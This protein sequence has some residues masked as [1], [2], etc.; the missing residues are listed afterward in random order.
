ML[1]AVADRLGDDLRRKVSYVHRAL[2]R[3]EIAPDPDPVALGAV[4][5]GQQLGAV[6][7]VPVGDEEL[8]V[9][10]VAEQRSSA[11]GNHDVIDVK[12]LLVGLVREESDW[13]LGKGRIHRRV[14]QLSVEVRAYR[15][16]LQFGADVMQLPLTDG[17]WQSH[18]CNGRPRTVL[19]DVLAKR[20]G[21]RPAFGGNDLPHVCI[22]LVGRAERPAARPADRHDLEVE[23]QRIVCP[24]RARDGEPEGPARD[25]LVPF[26]GNRE[27][28][29]LDLPR[30]VDVVAARRADL[31]RINAAVPDPV[32]QVVIAEEV[33]V[34]GVGG[35]KVGRVVDADRVDRDGPVARQ[36]EQQITEA[37]AVVCPPGDPRPAGDGQIAQVKSRGIAADL[38][39]LKPLAE[40]GP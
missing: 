34:V 37:P 16:A 17:L 23:V 7:V 14:N 33:S 29:L 35:A 2:R 12:V 27:H 31:L 24:L 3:V 6:P 21:V 22:V 15:G 1:C 13:A 26:E 32:H 25:V 39:K 30:T 8:S 10:R 28:P 40:R 19:A 4:V 5:N 36:I 38:E 20:V 9:E 11:V 18:R